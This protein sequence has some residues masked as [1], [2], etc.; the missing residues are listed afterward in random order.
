MISNIIK[1]YLQEKTP[2][3]NAEKESII[4]FLI[5]GGHLQEIDKQDARRYLRVKKIK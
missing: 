2:E 4:R 3:S 5:E 1:K